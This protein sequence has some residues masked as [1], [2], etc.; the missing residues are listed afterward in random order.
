MRLTKIIS[1]VI[2]NGKRILKHARWGGVINENEQLSSF[3]LDAT[4]PPGT[5]GAHQPATTSGRGVILGFFNRFFAALSGERRMYST[6]QDGSKIVTEIFQFNNGAILIRAG[7]ID[8]IEKYNLLI[9]SDGTVQETTPKKI[10]TGDVEINGNLI[11]NGISFGTHI[12]PYTDDG[13][14]LDTGAPE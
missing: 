2:S 6:L 5:K 12:H 3:G 13:V 14:P 9:D 7:I 11:I 1:S 4:P 8:G 10:I